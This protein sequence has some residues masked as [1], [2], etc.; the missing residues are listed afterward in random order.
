MIVLSFLL[1]ATLQSPAD[2]SGDWMF[3]AK[4]LNDVSYARVTLKAEGE[5]LSGNLNANKIEGTIKGNELTFK[6]TRPA[7]TEFG[8]FKGKLNGGELS[9]TGSWPGVSG[10]VS[11]SARRAIKPPVR[12]YSVSV[13]TR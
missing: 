6:A 10:D 12:I 2:A 9:G 3:T 11:W 4:V 7:G 8:D 1:A 5:K 13:A